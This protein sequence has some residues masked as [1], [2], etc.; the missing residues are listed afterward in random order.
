M[1]ATKWSRDKAREIIGMRLRDGMTYRAEKLEHQWRE[2]EIT[3]YNAVGHIQEESEPAGNVSINDLA[4]WMDAPADRGVGV[5]YTFK[6]YRFIHAQMSANPPAVQSKPTTSDPDDKRR[7]DAADKLCRHGIR[8]YDMQE[9]VDQSTAKV[10][11]YGTGWV[12]TEQ[13]PDLGDIKD[14]DDETGEVTMEGD[15]SITSPS[16]WDIWV[17]PHA[18]SW[19]EVNWVIERKWHSREEIE[20]K[21][22]DSL[23]VIGDFLENNPRTRTRYADRNGR[24]G[25]EEKKIEL[26]YYY[27]KG[28][29]SNGMAG[30]YVPFLEDGTTLEEVQ[31]NP[32]RFHSPPDDEELKIMLDAESAGRPYDKGPETALLPFHILTDIDVADQVYGKSFVEYEAPIQDV[33]NRIDTVYLDNAKSHGLARLVLPEGCEVGEKSMTNSPWD[34]IKTTGN[35]KPSFMTAPTIMPDMSQFRDRMQAGGDD[36]AGVNDSMFGKQEREQSGFSMQYATNQGNM[37]RRRLFNKYVLFVESIYKAYLSLIQR[38][39]TTA[40]TIKV[41]GREKAYEAI[42]IKGSDII[43]GFDLVVEYG[44]SFSLD[45]T[46][47]REEIMALLPLFEK[48]GVDYKTLISYLKLNEL[49]GMYDINELAATRQQEIFEHIIASKGEEYIPPKDLQEHQGMLAYCYKFVMTSEYRDLDAGIQAVIDRHVIDREEMA[50]QKMQAPEQPP[51]PP[52]EPGALPEQ[53]ALANNPMTGMGANP[54]TV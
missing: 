49:E 52:G 54:Q 47:R 48:A 36:V 53:G 33:L 32:F 1:K 42:D 22:P 5:N 37:I 23:A 11:L 44:H 38:H 18:R 29:P 25:L 7:A 19:K 16:T 40:R 45:P 24:D 43:R 10:L 20:S 39:W 9:V 15:L 27:E 41:L 3:I 26:F 6:H 34:I 30:R 12:K 51:G 31:K 13:D 17:D 2:N 28:L 8:G 35:Q 46:I 50:G 4:N 14:Y 21:F